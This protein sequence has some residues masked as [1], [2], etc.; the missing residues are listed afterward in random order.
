VL[1]KEGDSQS[2]VS[3]GLSG[4]RVQVSNEQL[5]QR[6]FTWVERLKKKTCVVSRRASSTDDSLEILRTC[7]VRSD[8]GDSR[9]KTNVDVDVLEDDLFLGV[10]ERDLVQLKQRRRDL[11]RLGELKALLV[12][13]L[14]RLELGQLFEDLDLGLGLSSPVG[15]VPP[16]VDERL[17]MLPVR[18][19]SFVLL[20]LGEQSVRLGRVEL[21]EVALEVVEP[22]RVLPDNVGSDGVEERSVVRDDDERGRPGLQVVFQ[23]CDGVEI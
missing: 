12:L 14:G 21:G 20:L 7:S 17:Q 6:R 16:P 8:D 2:T 15:V 4:Q 9:V 18:E 11:V 10:T 13:L 5:D 1:G 22:L 23:P 19:L 3:N